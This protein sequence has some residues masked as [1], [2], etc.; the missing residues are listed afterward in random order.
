LRSEPGSAV[1]AGYELLRGLI[2]TTG[3]E[4]RAT[5]RAR[6]FERFAVAVGIDRSDADP[7]VAP[8]LFAPAIQDWDAG[9]ALSELRADG[10]GADRTSFLPLEGFRLMGGGQ[11]L[12]FHAPVRDGTELR[13]RSTLDG[14]ELKHGRSGDLVI[15]ALTTVY[16]DEQGQPLITCR[17]TTLVR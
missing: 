7:A 14:V 1:A 11:E 16:A 8:L 15:L 13:I 10:T 17:D 9:P 5:V 12:E 3:P 4:L 6:D 2:G